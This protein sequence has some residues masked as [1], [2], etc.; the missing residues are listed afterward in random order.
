MKDED[1]VG[2]EDTAWWFEGMDDDVDG[3]NEEAGAK[4]EEEPMEEVEAEAAWL[5]VNLD[6]NAMAAASRASI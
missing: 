1:E 2:N 3:F 6:V 5:L 4:N